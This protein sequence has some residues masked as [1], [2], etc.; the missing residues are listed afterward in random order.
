MKSKLLTVLVLGIFMFSAGCGAII[1]GAV[2]G[3]GVYTYYN[4]ELTRT[5]PESYNKT[6]DICLDTMKELKIA[7][8]EKESD[9]ITTRIKAKQTDEKPITVKVIHVAPQLTEV[10]VRSGVFGVWDKKVSELIHA[11]IAKKIQS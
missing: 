7:I 3:A 9:E 5:Y 1:A 10:S 6:V 8:E 11:T 2:V 4:G